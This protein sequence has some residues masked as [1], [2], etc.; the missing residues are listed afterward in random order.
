MLESY[1]CK[2]WDGSSEGHVDKS[3]QKSPPESGVEAVT[4]QPKKRHSSE[5]SSLSETT[6]S[7]P[8]KKPRRKSKLLSKLLSTASSPPDVKSQLGAKPYETP[9]EKLPKNLNLRVMDTNNNN[10]ARAAMENGN[11]INTV[12]KS[13]TSSTTGAKNSKAKLTINVTLAQTGISQLSSSG[14]LLSGN[15]SLSFVTKKT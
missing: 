14:A 8:L 13:S 4:K 5:N 3:G 9:Q 2:L 10:G 6:N 11:N 12:R 1:L 15:L 7:I